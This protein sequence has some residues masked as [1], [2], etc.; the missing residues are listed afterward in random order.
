MRN[1]ILRGEGGFTSAN[2][3]VAGD[4]LEGIPGLDRMTVADWKA[5][6]QQYN[7]LGGPQFIEDTFLGAVSRLGLPDDTVMTGAVQL[8]LFDELVLGGV[9]RPRLSAYLNGTSDDL[10]GALE[11]IS[12]EWAAVANPNTGITSYPDVGGN[13]ASITSNEMA[14]VLQR[15]RAAR[16]ESLSQQTLQT[17]QG[18]TN[19]TNNSKHSKH[20]KHHNSPETV[21]VAVDR[22]A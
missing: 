20:S 13:A 5:L 15:L 11:D 21:L 18:S 16:L 2:R 9:K 7:A 10:Q 4:T 6:Y 12:L 3:G 14:E 17:P 8:Q 22:L 1:L 19:S